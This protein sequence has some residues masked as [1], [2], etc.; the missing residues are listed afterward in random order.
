M[1]TVK[2]I[3]AGLLVSLTNEDSDPALMG[4]FH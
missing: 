2:L 4:A 1:V 3:A